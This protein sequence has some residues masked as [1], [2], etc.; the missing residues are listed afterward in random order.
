MASICAQLE[1]LADEFAPLGRRPLKTWDFSFLQ[2][3]G[4][5][6]KFF[7]DPTEAVRFYHVQSQIHRAAFPIATSARPLPLPKPEPPGSR[8]VWKCPGQND[9][10]GSGGDDDGDCGAVLKP[11]DTS[12]FLH[13]CSNGHVQNLMLSAIVDLNFTIAPLRHALLKRL[14]REKIAG[15]NSMFL[16]SVWQPE[17]LDAIATVLGMDVPVVFAQTTKCV[18]RVRV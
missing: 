15:L 17:A 16:W 14:I 4:D 2:R 11:V 10:D 1:I 9:W 12:F 18:Y 3:H 8:R 5:A 6:G 7:T 13:R